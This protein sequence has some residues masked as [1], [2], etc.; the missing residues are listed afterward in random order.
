[1][2]V[3]D[4]IEIELESWARTTAPKVSSGFGP[5]NPLAPFPRKSGDRKMM[6][7]SALTSA[8]PPRIKGGKKVKGVL[9]F[10]GVGRQRWAIKIEKKFEQ[11]CFSRE[12]ET[13]VRGY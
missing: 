13:D 8:H 3:G 7:F 2:G 9:G 11:Q 6:I 1:M 12:V 5:E 10:W 4:G